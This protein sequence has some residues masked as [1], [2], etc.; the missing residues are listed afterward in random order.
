MSTIAVPRHIAVNGRLIRLRRVQMPAWSTAAGLAGACL[1]AGIYLLVLQ[2]DWHVHIGPV[3]F[4]ILNLKPGWD[5]LLPGKSWPLYRHG[6]RD[7][8][9]PAAAVMGVLTLLARP[10]WWGIRL[11]AWRLVVTPLILAVAAIVLITGGVWLLDFG[12]PALWHALLG[13]YRVTAPAWIAHSSWQDLL[14]GFLIGR[15]LHRI[16]APAGATLQGH[17]VDR[18]VDRAME[19]GHVPAWVG[20]PVV[21]P[22]IRE[23]FTWDLI[24]EHQRAKIGTR[25]APESREQPSRATRALVT[26][27]LVLGVLFTVAGVIAKFWIATGHGFPYLAP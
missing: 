27:L 5:G 2:V 12:L 16:W 24:R 10:R 19:T 3:Q 1:V 21:P 23:R 18:A 8:G 9:E 25:D 13:T 15:V 7:L 26:S 4:T 11:S 22:V 17:V 20:L 14:L 6:L